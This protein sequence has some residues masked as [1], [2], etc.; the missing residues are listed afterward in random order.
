[1]R[2]RVFHLVA[3]RMTLEGWLPLGC[4]GWRLEGP[5]T[6]ELE[7]SPGKSSKSPA[8]P[9]LWVIALVSLTT[10]VLWS[11]RLGTSK[12]G[13][14]RCL[15]DRLETLPQAVIVLTFQNFL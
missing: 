4:D 14:R 15:I 3:D 1:V 10:G 12:T 5:R 6:A 2:S 8:A 13:E 11:W 7:P 9:T